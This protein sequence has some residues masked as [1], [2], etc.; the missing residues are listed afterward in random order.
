MFVAPEKAQGRHDEQKKGRG[1]SE[2]LQSHGHEPWH[3][4]TA[5]DTILVSVP[6]PQQKQQ[7]TT[8]E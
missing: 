5:Y 4:T 6:P 2:L 1:I 7:K 3:I 8:N